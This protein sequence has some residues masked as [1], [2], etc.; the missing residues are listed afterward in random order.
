MQ[1]IK[2]DVRV[3]KLKI[4]NLS[5]GNTIIA[6]Q[7]RREFFAFFRDV[8]HISAWTTVPVQIEK[9]WFFVCHTAFD[10]SCVHAI[11]MPVHTSTC[12]YTHNLS[13]SEIRN[14]NNNNTIAFHSVWTTHILG[15]EINQ[16]WK[17]RK[18]VSKPKKIR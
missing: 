6:W 16:N 8:M 2:C 13:V 4:K 14:C 12:A 5:N 11:C 7:R 15:W 3:K 18:N 17:L 9:N 10:F 1:R